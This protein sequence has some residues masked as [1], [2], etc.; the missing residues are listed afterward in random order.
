LVTEPR[1][2][3]ESSLSW[4]LFVVSMLALPVVAL[5]LKFRGF[6]RTERLLAG[7]SSRGAATAGAQVSS[8]RARRM[9]RTVSMAATRGP[10]RAQRLEQAITLWWML[11]LRGIETSVRLGIYLGEQGSEA[12][13]WV[14][15]GDEVLIGEPALL[16]RE[17]II[18][19]I[20]NRN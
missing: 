19:V 1:A 11:G 10:Y 14:L 4:W 6:R 20:V 3:D 9:A 16:D 17:S 15:L 5:L 13:A 7:M 18:D 12:H 8:E 2:H